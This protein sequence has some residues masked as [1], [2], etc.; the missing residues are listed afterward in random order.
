MLV[1]VSEPPRVRPVSL[2]ERVVTTA[3]VPVLMLLGERIPLSHLDAEVLGRARVQV[4]PL[5]VG[6]GPFIMAYGLVELTALVIPRWRRWRH[7]AQGR[8][9]LERWSAALGIV[10]ALVQAW[11]IA[12]SLQATE[13]VTIAG[14]EPLVV[15]TATLT[16]GACAMALAARWATRRGL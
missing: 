3:L 6:L 10:L 16:G 9:R 1:G 11:S 15:H 8:V 13:I 14:W 5:A 4:S 12:G 7:D 2:L